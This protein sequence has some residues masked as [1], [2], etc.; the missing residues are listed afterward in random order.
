M[1]LLSFNRLQI[2]SVEKFQKGVE[3]LVCSFCLIYQSVLLLME[4]WSGATV[5]SI[6]LSPQQMESIPGLTICFSEYLSMKR[7]AE[8]KH[9][10]IKLFEYYTKINDKLENDIQLEIEPGNPILDHLEEI[11]KKF[12]QTIDYSIVPAYEILQNYS[13][14][15]DE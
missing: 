15:L 6:N 13:I 8:N 11:F 1:P 3:I 10:M 5:T 9:E 2:C 7:T 4:Y 12:K 14:L